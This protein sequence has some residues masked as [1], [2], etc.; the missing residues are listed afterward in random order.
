MDM[1]FEQAREL[2]RKGDAK[3]ISFVPSYGFDKAK[4]IILVDNKN[5]FDVSLSAA[6]ELNFKIEGFIK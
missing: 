1:R 3:P 2:L 5:A 4:L 6:Q